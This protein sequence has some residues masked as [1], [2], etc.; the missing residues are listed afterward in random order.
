MSQLSSLPVDT[1]Q[2]LPQEKEIMDVLFKNIVPKPIQDVKENYQKIE[3]NISV[4]TK[5][6]TEIKEVFGII[7]LFLIFTFEYT[8]QILKRYSPFKSDLIIYIIK[9][10]IIIIL[11]WI[12]KNYNLLLNKNL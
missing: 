1:S 8:D 3:K 12:F 11:Y 7:L 4:F 6:I 9:I 5:L 2:I 10:I